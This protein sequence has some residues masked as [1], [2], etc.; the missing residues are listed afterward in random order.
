MPDAD[1]SKPKLDGGAVPMKDLGA[2]ARAPS[3]IA[4]SKD[5]IVDKPKKARSPTKFGKA[6]P[7]RDSIFLICFLGILIFFSGKHGRPRKE[8]EDIDVPPPPTILDKITKLAFEAAKKRRK[9]PCSLFL[10]TGSIPNTGLSYFAGRDYEAGELL[11]QDFSTFPLGSKYASPSALVLKH[12]PVLTNVQGILYFNDTNTGGSFQ[13]RASKSIAVGDEIFVEYDASL[14]NHSVYNH[15]PC[16]SDYDMAAEIV[17]D[18][19]RSVYDHKTRDGTHICSMSPVMKLLK[20]SIARFN[21]M[22]ASMLPTSSSTSKTFRNHLPSVAVLRNQTLVNLQ[23]SAFCVNDI[24][25]KIDVNGSHSSI[26]QQRVEAGTVVVTLPLY[27]MRT[28]EPGVCEIENDCIVTQ[29]NC[30]EYG[31]ISV[32][33]C[34][35]GPIIELVNG[36]D[37]VHSVNVAYRW[38]AHRAVQNFVMHEWSAFSTAVMAWDVIALRNIEIGEKVRI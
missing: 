7:V 8:K 4:P 35:L 38:S 13:L 2:S 37:D 30:F 25:Q 34:P 5:P 27:L 26:M 24:Q 9:E 33:V 29:N 3:N 28:T 14:H 21:P 18:A 15:I 6:D 16:P 10:Y 36:D 31:N 22:I 11:L 12:H 20:R 19:L 17:R 23:Q 1:S 32:T